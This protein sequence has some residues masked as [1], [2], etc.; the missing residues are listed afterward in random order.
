M[1]RT[2]ALIALLACAGCQDNRRSKICPSGR[3]IELSG[4]GSVASRSKAEACVANWASRLAN[5]KAPVEYIATTVVRQC[6]HWQF[7]IRMA[8]KDEQPKVSEET[9]DNMDRNNLEALGHMARFSVMQAQ[10]GNCDP[11]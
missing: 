10:A 1:V 4:N 2:A 11:T 3:P 7:D 5:A 6:Q 8:L 9:L